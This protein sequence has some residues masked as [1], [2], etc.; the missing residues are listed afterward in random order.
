MKA[1]IPAR[2]RA[3]VRKRAGNRCEYCLLHEDDAVLPHEPDHIVA[4]KHGGKTDLE[5]LAWACHVCNNLKGSDI[6]SVDSGTGKVVRLFNPRS[7]AWSKHF[8]L[9]NGSLVPRTP[10]GRV[11]EFLLQFNRPENVELRQLLAKI[12]RYPG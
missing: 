4:R 2:L 10:E 1:H 5:N 11:T 12:E 8:R 6:A 3:Q 9:R 7:D